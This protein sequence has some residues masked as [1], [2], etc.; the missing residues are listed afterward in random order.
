MATLVR[1]N[2]LPTL[3]DSFFGRPAIV[4]YQ[5]PATAVPAVN[6]K[7]TETTYQL[8]LAAPGLR[9]D[10]FTV[11]VEQNKLTLAFKHEAQTD[12]KTETY[13][14]QEF[15]YSAFERSFRLPK[16]VDTEAIQASYTDGILNVTL[17]KVAPKVEEPT[18][19]QIAIS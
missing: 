8:Q 7:E 12:E 16:N 11:S 10:Q 1:Y 3:F 19:K 15:G 6:V 2:T 9:K 13:T 4:R 17:P 14:R 18:V 5:K